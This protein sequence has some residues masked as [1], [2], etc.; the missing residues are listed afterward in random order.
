V[1]ESTDTHVADAQAA[2]ENLAAAVKKVKSQG[3]PGDKEVDANV[4][5][6]GF[7][8]KLEDVLSL[9][10]ASRITGRESKDVKQKYSK[11]MKDPAFQDLTYSWKTSRTRKMTVG[12]MTLDRPLPDVAAV[13]N[14]KPMSPEYFAISYRPPSDEGKEKLH[15]EI[16]KS[17]DLKGEQ[18]KDVAHTLGGAI[19]KIAE[20]FRPV[21]GLGEVAAFNGEESRL[22]VNDR[23]VTFTVTVDVGEDSAVNEKKAVEFARTILARCP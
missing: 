8:T 13:G 15:A 18:Q 21:K 5:L 1:R 22:Y 10:T 19:A 20:S 12:S 16:D 9:E 6:L 4:C 3:M 7:A 23:G 2:V 17:K 11:V 14:F